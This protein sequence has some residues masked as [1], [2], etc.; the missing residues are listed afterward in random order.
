[1]DYAVQVTRRMG[2]ERM[3]L[4]EGGTQYGTPPPAEVAAA[5]KDAAELKTQLDAMKG[6]EAS[7]AYKAL[8]VK[9]DAAQQKANAIAAL[10]PVP[11]NNIQNAVKAIH[12][13]VKLQLAGGYMSN[14]QWEIG[15]GPA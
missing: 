9:F 7:D 15:Y 12:H 5:S 6:Q 1:M 4:T 10:V 3:Y 8:K 11:P 2:L 14:N 13:A